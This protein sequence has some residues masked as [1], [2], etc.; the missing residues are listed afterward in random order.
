MMET[1]LIYIHAKIYDFISKLKIS[2]AKVK[3]T[4]LGL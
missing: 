2:H 4:Y 1:K 3:G